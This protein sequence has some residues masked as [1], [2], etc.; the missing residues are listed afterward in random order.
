MDSKHSDWVELPSTNR[1][2]VRHEERNSVPLIPAY[3]HLKSSAR[4]SCRLS[5]SVWMVLPASCAVNAEP[6]ATWH[7]SVVGTASFGLPIRVY[8][9][10]DETLLLSRISTQWQWCLW[11]EKQFYRNNSLQRLQHWNPYVLLYSLTVSHLIMW[12]LICE[13]HSFSLQLL[14]A[15]VNNCGK[16]ILAGSLFS[17]LWRDSRTLVDEST[18]R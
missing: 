3:F 8:S 13:S 9:S 15:C 17:W 16:Q 6:E 12:L 4:C 18:T 7:E 10:C 14:D 1:P 5:P 11:L 2:L